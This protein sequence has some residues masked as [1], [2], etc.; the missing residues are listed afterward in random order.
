VSEDFFQ[1]RTF[2]QK[3]CD[4]GV[5]GA[6]F[7]LGLYYENGFGGRKDYTMAL[8]LFQKA[9]DGGEPDGCTH[10]QSLH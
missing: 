5:M 8:T 2:D 3:A 6:C 9:C 1:A 10:L 7:M 4:G